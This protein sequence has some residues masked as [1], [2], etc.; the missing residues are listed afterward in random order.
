MWAKSYNGRKL[1]IAFVVPSKPICVCTRKSETA[2]FPCKKGR[3]EK[4]IKRK[5]GEK[6]EQKKMKRRERGGSQ[7]YAGPLVINLCVSHLKGIQCSIHSPGFL[8][9]IRNLMFR[10]H[11]HKKK[12]WEH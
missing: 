7:V 5:G 3:G 11:S 9:L 4:Y 6:K 8:D 2:L 1:D 10:A 12:I